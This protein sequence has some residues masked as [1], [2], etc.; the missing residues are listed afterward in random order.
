MTILS[1]LPVTSV[2]QNPVSSPVS[3]ID[4]PTPSLEAADFNSLA[5]QFE[6]FNSRELSDAARL[7]ERGTQE[8]HALLAQPSAQGQAEELLKLE[9]L[10]RAVLHYAHAQGS[11]SQLNTHEIEA[12]LQALETRL[13][14]IATSLRSELQNASSN[15]THLANAALLVQISDALLKSASAQSQDHHELNNDSEARERAN[16]LL[17]AL[18][19]RSN[20]LQTSELSHTVR[21]DQLGEITQQLLSLKDLVSAHSGVWSYTGNQRVEFFAQIY[22]QIQASAAAFAA[23]SE[24]AES[25]GR[26]VAAITQHN[27]R[28]LRHLL[29]SE[30]LDQFHSA[31]HEIQEQL[32]AAQ[33]ADPENKQRILL[34]ALADAATL[35]DEAS[36]EQVVNLLNESVGENRQNKLDLQYAIIQRLHGSNSP[37]LT[38]ASSSAETL[39]QDILEHPAAELVTQG[40]E[41][42]LAHLI[43]ENAPIPAELSERVFANLLGLQERISQALERAQGT[44]AAS[45]AYAAVEIDRTLSASR[46]RVITHQLAQ[47]DSLTLEESPQATAEQGWK[48][49]LIRDNALRLAGWARNHI[50]PEEIQQQRAQLEHNLEH[51]QLIHIQALSQALQN[52]ELSLHD[53]FLY[54]QALAIAVRHLPEA[55]RTP[56]QAGLQETFR[57]LAL[58]RLQDASVQTQLSTHSS[59][60]TEA[61]QEA[62]LT[63]LNECLNGEQGAEWAARLTVEK[64]DEFLVGSFKAQQQI[65]RYT[66]NGVFQIPSHLNANQFNALHQA[67]SH[68][69]SNHLKNQALQ[70][71]EALQNF[72]DA[73]NDPLRSARFAR[74]VAGLYQQAG[75]RQEARA[76]LNRIPVLANRLD[77]NSRVS[78]EA[79]RE[80][81]ELA[82]IVPALGHLGLEGENEAQGMESARG[83]LVRL[84]THRPDNHLAQALL[85][86]TEQSLLI[87]RGAAS[88]QVLRALLSNWMNQQ[89]MENP[90]INGSTLGHEMETFLEEIQTSI[91]SGRFDNVEAALRFVL[92]DS[93][94]AAERFSNMQR[95]FVGA[96]VSRPQFDN[97]GMG[98]RTPPLQ[99]RLMAFSEGDGAWNSLLGAWNGRPSTIDNAN[100]PGELA[101]RFIHLNGGINTSQAQ[102]NTHSLGLCTSLAAHRFGYTQAATQIARSLQSHA[103]TAAAAQSFLTELPEV[104]QLNR[105]FSTVEEFIHPKTFEAAFKTYGMFLLPF[106]VAR[107]G[108]VSTEALWLSRVCLRGSF[109]VRNIAEAAVFTGMN[110]GVGGAFAA[111]ESFFSSHRH[112]G[113]LARFAENTSAKS[114]FREWASMF[115]T[116]VSCHGAGVIVRGATGYSRLG[117]LRALDHFATPLWFKR[118]TLASTN[119][120]LGSTNYLLGDLGSFY[121]GDLTNEFLGLRP[122]E[123]EANWRLGVVSKAWEQQKMHWGGKSFHVIAP[124]NTYLTH[125]EQHSA[126][127]KRVPEFSAAFQAMGYEP[128]SEAALSM[129]Q[130]LIAFERGTVP[131][132]VSNPQALDIPAQLSTQEVTRRVRE[133]VRGRA[134]NNNSVSYR[135]AADPG[136]EGLD[137]VMRQYYR[138]DPSTQQPGTRGHLDQDLARARLIALGLQ[139]ASEGHSVEDLVR[140]VKTLN[141]A[142]GF[143]GVLLRYAMERHLSPDELASQFAERG[144]EFLEELRERCAEWTNPEFA[145]SEQSTR[146]MQ[147]QLEQVF[148]LRNVNFADLHTNLVAARE[149]LHTFLS[150]AAFEGNILERAQLLQHLLPNFLMNEGQN[151]LSVVAQNLRKLYLAQEKQFGPMKQGARL[152]FMHEVLARIS[153]LDNS[154][155]ETNL[156]DLAEAIERREVR[157]QEHGEGQNLQVTVGPAV[158]SSETGELGNTVETPTGSLTKVRDDSAVET[159]SQDENSVEQREASRLRE[160]DTDDGNP[161]LIQDPSDIPNNPLTVARS[162]IAAANDDGRI[163]PL[164]P[165]TQVLQATGT[166]GAANP[167][168]LRQAAAGQVLSLH[169]DRPRA[170]T[171]TE[172]GTPTVTP[173]QGDSKGSGGNNGGQPEGG[174]DEAPRSSFGVHFVEIKAG[175]KAFGIPVRN[176][177]AAVEVRNVFTK[178]GKTRFE[179]ASEFLIA[180]HN[181]PIND[182]FSNSDKLSVLED[183]YKHI[184]KDYLKNNSI[185]IYVA[186]RGLDRQAEIITH[187]K[188]VENE[189][190]AKEIIKAPIR[191]KGALILKT[192]KGEAGLF[193]QFGGQANAYFKE[194]QYTHDARQR[195]VGTL[196]ERA[197]TVLAEDVRSAEA[198]ASGLFLEGFDLKAWLSGKKKVQESYLSSSAVSQP[199]IFLTQMANLLSF[200]R[201]QGF[202]SP[203]EFRK[204][205]KGVTGHS[206]GI[207]AADVLARSATYEEFIENTIKNARYLLW[208]GISMAESFPERDLPYDMVKHS[209]ATKQN[210]PTAMLGALKIK[211]GS[212]EEKKTLAALV[213]NFNQEMRE[214]GKLDRLCHISLRNS[215]RNNVVSGHPESIFLLRERLLKEK[216][217]KAEGAI[218]QSLIPFDQRKLE[219]TLVAFPVAAPFH[220]PDS[221]AKAAEMLSV[222]LERLGISFDPAGLATPTYSTA[223]GSNLQQSKNLTQDYVNMQSI[224]PV[225]WWDEA[226]QEATAENGVS[227]IL[228]FGPGDG[229]ANVSARNKQGSGVK[230]IAAAALKSRDAALMLDYT[231]LVDHDPSNVPFEA[232]WKKEYSPTLVRLPDGSKTIS[233]KFTRFVGRPPIVDGGKTPTTAPVGYM[234]AAVNSGY[235]IEWAGGGQPTE[236]IFRER[237]GKIVENLE[238]EGSAFTLNTLLIDPYLWGLHYPLVQ[239]VAREGAPIEG[240][241]IGAGVPSL[242]EG[243]KIIKALRE[244]GIQH[245]SFKPGRTDHILKII[246]IAKANPDMQIMMQWTGGLGGGHHSFEDK[247]EPILETYA[248]IRECDNLILVGGSGVG[249]A[250]SAMHLMSGRWSEEVGFAAMPFDAVLLGS[251][252]MVAEEST[253]APEVKAAIIAAQGVDESKWTETYKK[254]TGGVVSV[255]T[256]IEGSDAEIHALATRGAR[257]LKDFDRDYFRLKAPVKAGE[258]PDP[259]ANDKLREEAILRDKAKIIARINADFQRPYFGRNARGETV[260]LDQM[261]FEEVASRM[262]AIMFNDRAGARRPGW[263]DVTYRNRLASWLWHIEAKFAKDRKKAFLT[264]LQRPEDLEKDPR[265]FLRSF[266]EKYS[267]ARES[268]LDSS[269]VNEFLKICMEPGKPVNFVP[270]IDKNLKRWL[271]S[272]SLEYSE[273]LSLIHGQEGESAASLADRAFVLHGPVAARYSTDVEPIA[274]IFGDIHQG[275][276]DELNKNYKS[277]NEIPEVEYLG[278]PPI[279]RID[280]SKQLKGITIVEQTD[281]RMT[282]IRIPGDIE[283]LPQV[284]DWIQYLAGTEASWIRAALM[285]PQAVRGKGRTENKIPLFFKPR[286][287]QTLRIHRNEAGKVTSLELFDP[288][289]LVINP[290][291]KNPSVV[292]RLEGEKILVTRNHVRPSTQEKASRVIALNLEYRYNPKHGFAPLH[293]DMPDLNQRIKDFY[294]QLWFDDSIRDLSVNSRFKHKI[295]LTRD[296]IKLFNLAIR[297]RNEQFFDWGKGANLVG[298]PDIIILAAWESMIKTLFPPEI[299]GNIFH[300]VHQWNEFV[301]LDTLKEGDEIEVDFGISQVMNNEAGKDITVE[302][303]LRVNGGEKELPLNSSFLIRDRFTDF[304]NT[305][306][307]K[308]LTREVQLN[309]ST[310]VEILTSK[311]WIHWEEGYRPKLEDRLVFDLRMESRFKDNKGA[312]ATTN[313]Q[314]VIRLGDRIVG[315]VKFDDKDVKENA[316]Q[317]YLLAHGHSLEIP[318]VLFENGGYNLI[319]TD[320]KHGLDE[321]TVPADNILY[322]QASRDLNPIH[323]DPLMA[324]YAKLPSTITH[325]LFTSANGRR[326]LEH[327]AA[328]GDAKRVKSYTATFVGMVESG[329]RLFSQLKH[330]GMKDGLQIVEIETRNQQGK[331]VLK[332][333]GLVEPPLEFIGFTGQ[334]N[335]AAIPQVVPELYNKSPVA[336]AIWNRADKHFQTNFGFSLLQIA[337]ENPKQV[338]VNFNT[339]QGRKIREFYK[340]HIP[341]IT[342]ETDYYVFQ[343]PEGLINSTQFTQAII[344]IHEKALFEY[345]RSR[346]LVNRNAFVAGHSLGEYG[347]LAAVLGENYARF[348]E[349][350]TSDS[351]IL[352]LE[353]IAETTFLRGLTMQNAVPRDAKGRSPYCMVALNPF[354]LRKGF[355]EKDLTAILG[356]LQGKARERFVAGRY[357]ISKQEQFKGVEPLLEAVNYN[358]QDAQYVLAG[359]R[360]TLKAFE[361]LCE[362]LHK[363]EIPERLQKPADQKAFLTE[364]LIGLLDASLDFALEEQAKLEDGYFKTEEIKVEGKFWTGLTVDIPFHSLALRGGVEVFR[365]VLQ[366]RFPKRI[367]PALLVGKYIPNL[368]G[369]V[370]SLERSYIEDIV[371]NYA[372]SPLL[373]EVL[374]NWENY[375][376]E[377]LCSILVIELLSYQFASPVRFIETMDHLFKNGVERMLEIGHQPTLKGFLENTRK[378]IYKNAF[379]EG[380]EIGF[381][382]DE[383]IADY[384]RENVGPIL[385]EDLILQFIESEK[386]KEEKEEASVSSETT[387]TATSPA[388]AA[389]ATEKKVVSSGYKAPEDAAPRALDALKLLTMV[390]FKKKFAD[391]KDD[392]TIEEVAAGDSAPANELVTNA[393]NEFGG[394]NFAG[395]G[396]VK[397][398]DLA[399]MVTNYKKIGPKVNE[400]LTQNVASKLPGGFSVSKLREYLKSEWALGEGRSEGV[401][402]FALV[403]APEKRFEDETAAKVW[404]DRVVQEYAT[405]QKIELVKPKDLVQAGGEGGNAVDEAVLNEYKA[406][407][408]AHIKEMMAAHLHFL[409]EDPQAAEKAIQ[410]ERQLR[411]DLEKELDA[412]RKEHGQEYLDGIRGVFSGKKFRNYNA[413]WAWGRQDA[414]ILFHDLMNRRLTLEDDAIFEKAFHLLNR[415][416]PELLKQINFHAETAQKAKRK[417]VAEFFADMAAKIQTRLDTKTSPRTQMLEGSKAPRTTF[418]EDGSMEFKEVAREGIKTGVDYVNEME[419]GGQ[420][421]VTRENDENKRTLLQ[422]FLRTQKKLVKGFRDALTQDLDVRR[423]LNSALNAVREISGSLNGKK[424]VAYLRAVEIDS[425]KE[426][427]LEQTQAYF[428]TLHDMAKNGLSLKGKV[429]L[430]TGAGPDSIGLAMIEDLLRAGATVICTTSTFSKERTDF[431]RRIYKNFGALEGELIVLPFNQGSVADVNGLVDYIYSPTDAK[432]GRAK[433]L[434]MDIDFIIPFAAMEERGKKISNLDNKSELSHRIMLTNTLRLIGAVRNKKVEK[435][436]LNRPAHVVV[437]LSP[438]DGEFGGDGLYAESK[439]GL[440]SLL[441]KIGSEDHSNYLSISGAIIGWTRTRLMR[442]NNAVAE[443]MEKRGVRTFSPR[444][445]AF[446]LLALLHPRM[447]REAQK[448]ALLLNLNGGFEEIPELANLNRSLGKEILERKTLK[449]ALFKENAR[450]LEALG[451]TETKARESS[452]KAN[453]NFGF[454]AL[455]SLERLQELKRLQ[456][457]H[458]L[459]KV[460]VAVGFGEVS[461]WGNAR[462][463]WEM[464]STGEFSMEG[465]IEMAWIIGK[466][467]YHNGPLEIEGKMQNYAGWIDIKTKAPV[468]AHEVKAKYEKEIL[469]HS[470]IRIVEPELVHGYDPSKKM[471][472]REVAL[473]EDLNNIEVANEAEADNFI[474]QHGKDKAIKQQRNGTWF[475]TL[476]AG[477]V[478]RVARAMKFNRF[479]AGQI[480]TGFDPTRYGIPE[481]F[482]KKVDPTTLYTLIST[483]EALISAGVTDPYEFY[484][485]I[486]NSKL[487]NTI[488]GGM[489]GMNSIRLSFRE[490]LLEAQV[491]SNILQEQLINVIPAWVNMM[492]LSASGP[493]ITPVGAC[494]TAAAS[495]EAGAGL[496]EQGK[497]KIVMVGGADDFGEEGSYEFA[498]MQATNNSEEDIAAGRVPAEHCRPA[499][500]TRAGFLES[501]GAG[502]QIL[503]SADMAILMGLP[504]YG[505]VALT[506]TAMDGQGSSV[507]APGQGILTSAQE[508]KSAWRENDLLDFNTRRREVQSRVNKIRASERRQIDKMNRT[509]T[510]LRASAGESAAQAFIWGESARIAIDTQA[511]I[512]MVHQKY[513]QGFWRTHNAA[514]EQLINNNEGRFSDEVKAEAWKHYI[515][516]LRGALAVWGLTPD[517]IEFASFHGTSTNANDYN[518]SQVNDKQQLHLERSTGNPLLTIWQK[519]LTGHPKGAAAAF[520]ANGALQAMQTGIVPGNQNLDNVDPA[521]RKN[522]N[523]VFLDSSVNHGRSLKAGLLKSFGFGQAGGEVLLINPEYLFASLERPVFDRYSQDRNK[524]LNAAHQF[525]MNTLLGRQN[526]INFKSAPPYLPEDR[527]RVFTD[528]SARARWSEKFKCWIYHSDDT[529][530]ARRKKAAKAAD[531]AAPVSA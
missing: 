512:S 203:A 339:E 97:P 487:G 92:Q 427:N 80:I 430:V 294:A 306:S 456:G 336:K 293:E 33:N 507:P 153:P 470:G 243:T 446:N 468:A 93:P 352:S 239:V 522:E 210:E 213:E 25:A 349:T 260:D 130:P 461:P 226:T 422:G 211:E 178:S 463:R 302:G 436:I 316:V 136:W 360:T 351:G 391:I 319:Q 506:H 359:D 44:E 147:Q 341:G 434:G 490:R 495:I 301:K 265:A 518:E 245:I 348:L 64:L 454:P 195:E 517:D 269:D 149:T 513:G 233:S 324:Q 86:Q 196:L 447:I 53:R 531:A 525:N 55:S 511:D 67:L 183:T 332:G 322:A 82:E 412:I 35:Q 259:A 118:A 357:P 271:K 309:K 191:K 405:A 175:G 371:K 129:V 115:T 230:V 90:D 13:G 31:L 189:L 201:D 462:T 295:T 284:Q 418:K 283:K 119:V 42:V 272:D 343:H 527:D 287:G 298:A 278:G 496:I 279:R 20:L 83:S 34:G 76:A 331:L 163:T 232:N 29:S 455:P 43:S 220:T 168:V 145:R 222:H 48:L 242:E 238:E 141:G 40:K 469:E 464:E 307:N 198:Q 275:M 113:A 209:I 510:E 328:N 12:Q 524:R 87:A 481:D 216:F 439:L 140:Q 167:G 28:N 363:L 190:I 444:E 489:G 389:A 296:Q 370:F 350:G 311:K 503:M 402:I 530:E 407:G 69:S 268:V 229:I 105:L 126:V 5:F 174:K 458:D 369:K 482:A 388:P 466:I 72:V 102:F 330:I 171:N 32:R 305:F 270:V 520:M 104:E 57:T 68:F 235:H 54:T 353:A 58:S 486:H 114:L 237:L 297:N 187:F 103:E 185:D 483:A 234:S 476:K 433:G 493:V 223:D 317:S 251:R 124:M 63:N 499:T 354:N 257:M 426:T 450:E 108:A 88:T 161:N 172:E 280:P 207:M 74:E 38:Q 329:D 300:L 276:I 17:E 10:Y 502:V 505:I 159:P 75:L 498:N 459:S 366:E 85:S 188:Q 273:D 292:L 342:D 442:E 246:E 91:A 420:V 205:V 508:I 413:A 318:E 131:G 100:T 7:L 435:N 52:T 247:Y 156:H 380:R 497:A 410:M 453:F 452:A 397:F 45:L 313:A 111:Y 480:P 424:S 365:K 206:Q 21:T 152:S 362:K 184:V 285:S 484:Q 208:Q 528:P 84:L 347:A 248:K 120:L 327:Y 169:A 356:A 323:V 56:L 22:T 375:Q 252:T 266:F 325:G 320:K 11:A 392:A 162:R 228:C 478:I 408:E 406:R 98:G 383:K 346:G 377:E 515:S 488:G 155:L 491:Q 59:R 358:I 132:W 14:E 409:G 218:D 148:S 146:W 125:T 36:L 186:T 8:A 15:G 431:Y 254:P 367:N 157:L 112:A 421:E 403:S 221:M 290:E 173:S 181:L 473:T 150:A 521:L 194:L 445:M 30:G 137:A 474:L 417:E 457:M 19:L 180:A 310:D 9:H 227:H 94:R 110:A 291:N 99:D 414:L 523:L 277:D 393:K 263:I 62:C 419:R 95:F 401:L 6:H 128:D 467:K 214:Q 374:S 60:N 47:T 18:S 164:E 288:S 236:K 134:G 51:E 212:A 394:V 465:C 27:Q 372:D 379:R 177:P 73:Q 158:L 485:Y 193:V 66:H 79:A 395:K 135:S 96:G 526:L 264:Q 106:G 255:Q 139:Y 428:E 244:A 437:P 312:L 443:E 182:N 382:T 143:E 390:A 514:I 176:W 299:N 142:Q 334:G 321:M 411:N 46:E 133:L 315:R 345:R 166:D 386:P 258:K 400:L 165:N 396:S 378:A 376:A 39:I 200:M 501:Q 404:I 37:V 217:V 50:R 123:E 274:K 127:L 256:P 338:R 477:A 1:R 344:L 204:L 516:P 78:A 250:K 23:G 425:P 504:I 385:S 65:A 509:A 519:W 267:S 441:K 109:V 225:M 24:H 449:E 399:T 415:A 70:I 81:R 303:M 289:D 26:L 202:E 364:A 479:V 197:G 335:A 460:T 471:F 199:L 151:S 333:R 41:L 361:Y 144:R 116:F 61:L 314:G 101:L 122:H 355:S 448:R 281:T 89:L 429:A 4:S 472:L 253:T 192:E 282:E 368:N 384:Q 423:L 373:K 451:R 71:G 3:G 492:L 160:N 387:P 381:V 529:E 500:D 121:A 286:A 117:M 240:L 337:K 249:D 416:T 16:H 241:A 215:P 49:N 340:K 179:S 219:F 107:L 398:S 261:N 138:I 308:K 224:E 2:V 475:V 440:R 304:E 432:E 154:T 262:I 231:H 77:N 326:V 438:N 170:S 494:A